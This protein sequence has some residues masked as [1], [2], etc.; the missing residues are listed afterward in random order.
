MRLILNGSSIRVTHMGLDFVLI[1]SPTD[2]PPCEAFLF[3]KVD[4]SESQWKVQLP[5]GISKGSNRVVLGLLE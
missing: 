1:E 4:E 5:E 2:H 3:L